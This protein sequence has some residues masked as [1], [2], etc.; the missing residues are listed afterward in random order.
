MCFVIA[1]IGELNTE[2]RKH[3]NNLIKDL[4]N[5]DPTKQELANEILHLDQHPDDTASPLSKFLNM[6]VLKGSDR[7]EDRAI[8]EVLREIARIK[9]VLMDL[10]RLPQFTYLSEHVLPMPPASGL[11]SR[12]STAT[13]F[14][15][16]EARP[17]DSG[18]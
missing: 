8:G 16:L 4:D 17:D 7:P 11:G 12:L 1:P 14:N 3:S 13:V 10:G 6:L 5:V 15:L 18:E 9:A 2:T